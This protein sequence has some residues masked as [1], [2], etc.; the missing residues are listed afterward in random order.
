MEGTKEDLIASRLNRDSITYID[1]HQ[2]VK[3]PQPSFPHKKRSS[4]MHKPPMDQ[5]IIV[6]RSRS[7]SLNDSQEKREDLDEHANLRLTPKVQA[8]D[9]STLQKKNG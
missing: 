1:D 9:L 7:Q 4:D 3:A 2:A 5:K 8:V 6:R